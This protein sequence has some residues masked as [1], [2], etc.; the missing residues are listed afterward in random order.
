M[1]SLSSW[2]LSDLFMLLLLAI[3]YGERE[4]GQGPT[5][6]IHPASFPAP[7]DPLCTPPALPCPPQTV[8]APDPRQGS[9]AATKGSGEQRSQ[10]SRFVFPGRKEASSG[11]K[12]EEL[13]VGLQGWGARTHT[14]IVKSKEGGEPR[15]PLSTPGSPV[16]RWT[17][18]NPPHCPQEETQPQSLRPPLRLGFPITE[19]GP[20]EPPAQ[21]FGG[22]HAHLRLAMRL[23]LRPMP[24]HFSRWGAKR[25]AAMLRLQLGH[26]HS[27]FFHWL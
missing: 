3:L 19:G 12:Q 7:Q 15:C 23:L 6:G 21:L 26:T 22:G 1:S 8:P 27:L 9:P 10:N 2:S 25:E 11:L 5:A 16:L 18:P 20:L 17:C 4:G 14:P 24:R 13:E